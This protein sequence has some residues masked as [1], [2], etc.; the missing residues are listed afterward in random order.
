MTHQGKYNLF[1][2]SKNKPKYECEEKNFAYYFH[3]I[4]NNNIYNK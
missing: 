4:I 1:E 3:Q 2:Y